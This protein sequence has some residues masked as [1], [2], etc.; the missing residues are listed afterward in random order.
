VCPFERE[1]YSLKTVVEANLNDKVSE[2][3]EREREKDTN[4]QRE[5]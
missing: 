2:H 5:R 4:T 1:N 3:G